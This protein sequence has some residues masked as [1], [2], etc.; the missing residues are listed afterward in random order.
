MIYTVYMYFCWHLKTKALD[1]QALNYIPTSYSGVKY[2]LV[3]FLNL[4]LC[5]T[6]YSGAKYYLV[7]FLNLALIL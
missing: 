4:A 6:S 7:T 5:M 3:T 2:Y 1:Q